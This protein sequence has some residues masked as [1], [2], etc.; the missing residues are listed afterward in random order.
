MPEIHKWTGE[1]P[2]RIGTTHKVTLEIDT[3]GIHV[4][5]ERPE[6]PNSLGITIWMTELAE[7]EGQRIEVETYPD[8]IY[9]RKVRYFFSLDDGELVM[10][11]REET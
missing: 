1:F 5:I 6:D 4:E 9:G 10:Q 3:D 8:G 11:T 7:S 2:G